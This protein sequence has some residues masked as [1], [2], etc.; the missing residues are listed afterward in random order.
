MK[1]RTKEYIGLFILNMILIG[2]GFILG[3]ITAP[4]KQ[5]KEDEDE[6]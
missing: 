3:R 1:K 6:E 2:Y 5:E 4:S